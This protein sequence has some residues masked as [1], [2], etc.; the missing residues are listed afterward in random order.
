MEEVYPNL[1]VGDDQDY[2]TLKD[3]SGW[4]FVRACKEGPGGHR[5]T[6]HYNTLGAP[7]GKDYF[8]VRKVNRLV[9]NLIDIDDPAYVRDDTINPALK[10]IKDKLE[11]GDKVLCACN[12]GHSRG[13]TVALMFLRTIG[14]MP[15]HFQKA[16]KIYKT[17]YKKYDPSQGIRQYA[18]SHWDKLEKE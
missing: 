16:E 4:C 7:K 14:D 3:K 5:D 6:L 8:F 11:K 10:F 17:L 9:M 2:L 18:K 15:Y 1:Y 13:P 12:K